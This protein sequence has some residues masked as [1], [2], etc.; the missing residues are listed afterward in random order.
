MPSI[1]PIPRGEIGAITVS[2]KQDQGTIVITIRD[3]GL[4]QDI[5]RLEDALHTKDTGLRRQTLG[6]DWAQS[7]DD[8]HWINHGPEGKSLQITKQLHEVHI[9]A[10]GGDLQPFSENPPLAPAQSYEIRRMRPDEAVQMCQLIY[11][12]YGASY[13]N[14]DIY[15]PDRVVAANASG[16]VL[17]YV[18]AGTDG[19]LVGHYALERNQDG[20]VAEGGQAVVDPS[21]RGRNLLNLMKEAAIEGARQ[22]GLE[23]MYGDAVTVHTFSQK[24]NIEHGAFLACANLGISPRTETFR[25]VTVTGQPQRITCLLYFLWL[26]PPSPRTIFAPAQH[27]EAITKLY[28]HL[29]CPVSFGPGGNACADT[30]EP[31]IHF[32][33]GAAVA[34]LRV[35]QIGQDTAAAI[36]HAKREVIEHSH[37][38][39]LFA[40]L[41]LAQ[42]GTPAIAE[43]LEKEGFSFAGITPRFIPEGDLLRL[44]YLTEE[45]SPDPIKIEEEIGH[46]LVD[47]ALADRRR[48]LSISE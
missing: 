42:P 46:W 8:L 18:A 17:S 48:V 45:L 2:S 24:A 21:H 38:E 35:L 39:A 31:T 10:H 20:P 47:Y 15:Y 19:N 32:D 44:V 36:R 11:K 28:A 40:E 34:F 4:P 3:Y 41:P 13:F 27:L 26:Q 12:A 33:S 1:T 37:A 7:A 14:R 30:G 22:L 5:Q 9:T 6:L 29:N 23:G 43:A 25:G 16:A